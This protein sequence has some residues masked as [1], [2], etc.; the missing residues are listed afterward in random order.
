MLP[1]QDQTCLVKNAHSQPVAE[2]CS[3]R[4]FLRSIVAFF[5][6]AVIFLFV[7]VLVRL[8]SHQG[9]GSYQVVISV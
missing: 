9:I 7:L 8:L 3:R 6:V 1:T 5:V 4:R 2:A